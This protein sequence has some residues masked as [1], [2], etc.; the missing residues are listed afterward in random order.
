MGRKKLRKPKKEPKTFDGLGDVLQQEQQFTFRTS[1]GTS[2]K[3]DEAN[4]MIADFGK[5]QEELGRLQWA[6]YAAQVDALSQEIGALTPKVMPG[7]DPLITTGVDRMDKALGEVGKVFFPQTSS[8]KQL[9]FSHPFVTEEVLKAHLT[10]EFKMAQKNTVGK[11][12]A[13]DYYNFYVQD[14]NL[15]K[16][17]FD[18]LLENDP[19]IVELKQL[20]V[21][22]I[23]GTPDYQELVV[24][25]MLTLWSELDVAKKGVPSKLQG[26]LDQIAGSNEAMLPSMLHLVMNKMRGWEQVLHRLN[27]EEESFELTQLQGEIR[28]TREVLGEM[29]SLFKARNSQHATQLQV[30]SDDPPVH[31]GGNGKTPG[32]DSSGQDDQRTVGDDPGQDHHVLVYHT[33]RPQ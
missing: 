21:K 9:Y 13:K 19:M 22:N 10:R 24:I 14:R 26:M 3:L 23:K 1:S 25:V 16:R 29:L 8:L 15:T 11:K 5:M 17:T 7:F 6:D 12:T 28:E 4:Q 18:Q 33:E 2:L 27:D 31:A 32:A 20:F 30:T